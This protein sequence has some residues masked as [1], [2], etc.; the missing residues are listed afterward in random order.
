MNKST[1]ASMLEPLL[2]RAVTDSGCTGHVTPHKSRLINVKPCNHRFKAA[3]G[4]LA[5]ATCIGDMPVLGA[6]KTGEYVYFVITG[7]R[8]VPGFEFTLLSV[9]QLW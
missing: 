7:V 4:K 1:L 2:I 9:D 8:C 6:S 5:H 3:N